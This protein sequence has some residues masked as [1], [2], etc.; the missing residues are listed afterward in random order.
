[1][2]S[3]ILFMALLLPHILFAQVSIRNTSLIK[4][5]TNLL[6]IGHE[7]MFSITGAPKN[8]VLKHSQSQY[9]FKQN[10]NEYAVVPTGIGFDTLQIVD[11]KKVIFEKAYALLPLQMPKIYVSN[12]TDTIL[13]KDRLLMIPSLTIQ[14]VGCQFDFKTIVRRYAV[15]IFRNEIALDSFELTSSDFSQQL[16]QVLKKLKPG[17]KVHFENIR[18]AWNPDYTI[19]AFGDKT[20]TIR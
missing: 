8:A 14:A 20:I 18:A 7:Q 15:T 6:Y 16:I 13:S 19:R 2:K 17:D 12:S 1:M 3:I 9:A 5:D 4:P 11:G 10:G